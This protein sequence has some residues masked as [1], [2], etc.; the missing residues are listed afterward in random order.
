M[1]I[2]QPNNSALENTPYQTRHFESLYPGGWRNKVI[3]LMSQ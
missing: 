1:I 2:N 3:A